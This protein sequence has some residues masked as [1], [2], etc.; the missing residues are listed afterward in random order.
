MSA[1]PLKKPNL[2][3]LAG[4]ILKYAGDYLDEMAMIAA[5]V[6]EFKAATTLRAKL[7][8]ALKAAK[9]VISETDTKLDDDLLETVEAVISLPAVQRLL[10]RFGQKAASPAPAPN[11]PNPFG[12]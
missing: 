8:V 4:L 9:L 12:F 6:P 3:E 5:M 10:A 1:Q 2:L 7:D 11:N